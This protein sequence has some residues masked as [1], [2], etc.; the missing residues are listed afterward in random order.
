M[1]KTAAFVQRT[2]TNLGAPWFDESGNPLPYLQSTVLNNNIAGHN[3]LQLATG[4]APLISADTEQSKLSAFVIC[5]I[6]QFVK[7]A[8]FIVQ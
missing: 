8:D 6:K 3:K 1:S 7:A 5:K 4:P 2:I